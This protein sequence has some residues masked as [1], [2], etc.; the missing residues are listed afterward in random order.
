MTGY[1]RATLVTASVFAAFGFSRY[2]DEFIRVFL[3]QQTGESFL[4][5]AGRNLRLSEAVGEVLT[6]MSFGIF[7]WLAISFLLVWLSEERD[8]TLP[9]DGRSMRAGHQNLWPR[10]PRA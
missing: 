7:L 9:A 1:L 8:D 2:L 5:A 6:V 3:R 10:A 4:S